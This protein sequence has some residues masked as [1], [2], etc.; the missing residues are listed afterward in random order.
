MLVSK[1]SVIVVSFNTCDKLRRCLACIEPHHEIIVVDNDS[2]DGSA[3]MVAFEYPNVKLV[4]NSTNLGFGAANNL[5]CSQATHD[6]VLFLNSDAY[7]DPGAI[8]MLATMFGDAAVVAAGGK[9][10]NP[11]RSLQASTANR[12]TLWAVFCEQSLLEKAFPNSNFF[13][14][15]WTT[16]RL[17]ATEVEKP[18]AQLM[19]AC[20]MVRAKAGIPVEI[21][22]DRYFLYCED[23]D[24][25]RRLERQ[26]KLVYVPT[27]K[28]VH[29]LGSSSGKDPTL[30]II[31]YNRGKEL[32]FRINH[33]DSQSI[34]C[35]LLDRA[36][37][38]FRL[39]GWT[40]KWLV[41]GFRS[42]RARSQISTFWRV[43][44]ASNRNP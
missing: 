43:L 1:V 23:T 7:A 2:R 5:G 27:A 24:L 14:P 32:Y 29:D 19:G 28:F 15:Y 44:T 20:I 31:R 3:D 12:L 25:C 9:L 40:T 38:K 11:D 26:G 22:D 4:R 33:S 41:S 35:W 16:S 36:G 30:G 21:F 42:E 37:A 8:N 13:A 17:A 39:L 34:V 6:L 18:T 10:L